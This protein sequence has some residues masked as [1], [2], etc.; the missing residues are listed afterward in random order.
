MDDLRKWLKKYPNLFSEDTK[1]EWLK[2]V[3][4]HVEALSDDEVLMVAVAPDGTAL[5]PV[6]KA[7]LRNK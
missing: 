5:T 1:Q 3:S 6:N 2:L 4:D 7:L